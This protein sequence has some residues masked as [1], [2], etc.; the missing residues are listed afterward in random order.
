MLYVFWVTLLLSIPSIA[1][2]SLSKQQ[3]LAMSDEELYKAASSGKAGKCAIYDAKDCKECFCD[4]YVKT[5]K[6]DPNGR[7]LPDNYGSGCLVAPDA[8][9][10]IDFC[11]GAPNTYLNYNNSKTPIC[12]SNAVKNAAN[13]IRIGI[14]KGLCDVE[15]K[16]ECKNVDMGCKAEAEK[17]RLELEKAKAEMKA[18]KDEKV[19]RGCKAEAEKFRLELE[20]AKAEMNAL[21]NENESLKKAQAN[22]QSVKQELDKARADMR[23]LKTENDS[24]KAQANRQVRIMSPIRRR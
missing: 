20:K 21:K 10:R 18:L 7:G 14:Q 3:L 2:S 24:L 1:Q 5:T 16:V 23:V 8:P 17:F 13:M 19:D 15:D 4:A 9:R 12:T 6:T 22:S 11:F